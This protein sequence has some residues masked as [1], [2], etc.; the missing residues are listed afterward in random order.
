MFWTFAGFK[1]ISIWDS[2]VVTLMVVRPPSELEPGLL[3]TCLTRQVRWAPPAQVRLQ[4][5]CAP[6]RA[7]VRGRP[8][9]HRLLHQWPGQ[10]AAASRNRLGLIDRWDVLPLPF[11]MRFVNPG[12]TPY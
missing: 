4:R 5:H 11:S 10:L 2:K 9:L 8:D 12:L 1:F 7:S 3:P 6:L